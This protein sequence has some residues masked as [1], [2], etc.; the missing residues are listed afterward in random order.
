MTGPAPA[1]R[2]TIALT[3]R[4]SMD[5]GEDIHFPP[6]AALLC[7]DLPAAGP[8]TADNGVP[9]AAGP[10]SKPKPTSKAA[11]AKGKAAKTPSAP[12]GSVHVKPKQ[13]KS[14]NGQCYTCVGASA[15]VLVRI[16]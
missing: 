15:L 5:G 3:A 11:L 13:S 8:S 7:P 10:V 1:P 6:P 2:A 4:A 12:E 9:G 16:C 14:R